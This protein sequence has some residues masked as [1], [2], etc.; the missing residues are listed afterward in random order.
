MLYGIVLVLLIY[1]AWCMYVVYAVSSIES[2]IDPESRLFRV[3]RYACGGSL[4]LGNR[5]PLPYDTYAY[6]SGLWAL[7][8]YLLSDVLV[9][10]VFVIFGTGAVALMIFLLR[11]IPEWAAETTKILAV[12]TIEFGGDLVSG[13]P[14]AHVLWWACGGGAALMI[15]RFILR[16]WLFWSGYEAVGRAVDFFGEVKRRARR[17]VVVKGFATSEVEE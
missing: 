15:L 8:W 9:C 5:R 1:L 6:W 17:P 2:E 14:Y 13:G 4:M 3:Y 12:G 11:D 7:P 10:A 16:R